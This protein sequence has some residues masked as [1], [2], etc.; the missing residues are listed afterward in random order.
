MGPV[1]SVTIPVSDAA[2]VCAKTS[3]GMSSPKARSRS[4]PNERRTD[5]LM[6]PP[7]VTRRV[8]PF[9]ATSGTVAPAL[10]SVARCNRCWF[11]VTMAQP[12]RGVKRCWG[13][14][15]GRRSGV[16]HEGT[17]LAKTNE[18]KL[19]I[20]ICERRDNARG[21]KAS[22]SPR[23]ATR[24][25]E[26]VTREQLLSVWSPLTPFLRVELRFLRN[27]LDHLSKNTSSPNFSNSWKLGPTRAQS[28]CVVFPS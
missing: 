16:Q 23:R 17:E 2:P 20:A 28:H 5:L 1:S 27:L 8:E 18:G 9:D 10:N 15:R 14:R 24:G 22:R 25:G 21:I 26:A 3:P 4:V 11:V 12:G 19:L 6:V 7:A 13:R